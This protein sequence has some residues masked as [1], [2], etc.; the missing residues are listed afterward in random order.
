MTRGPTWMEHISR[1]PPLVDSLVVIIII[2]VIVINLGDVIIAKIMIVRIQR[3][4]LPTKS[5]LHLEQFRT[6]QK[7]LAQLF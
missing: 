1:S 3:R 2:S 5:I 6:N 4:M 7:S